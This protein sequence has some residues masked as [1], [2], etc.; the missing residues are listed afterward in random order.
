MIK[1]IAAG[2][3]TVSVLAFGGVA[4]AGAVAPSTSTTAPQHH[5]KHA[6]HKGM[7]ARGAELLRKAAQIAADT[8]GI[9]ISTLKTEV[10]AKGSIA[11]VAA[12]HGSSGQAVIDALVAKGN[13]AIDK[14][15]AAG[16]ITNDQATAMR[17][18]LPTR[19]ATFVNDTMQVIARRQA[20]WHRAHRI[21]QAHRATAH[22]TSA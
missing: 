7:H 6:G 17:A 9:D 22:T 1:R 10:R 20:R 19:A 3:A 21:G 8:I 15:L 16:R 12:D 13:A 14:A 11:A 4:V 5:V 18:K 2:V